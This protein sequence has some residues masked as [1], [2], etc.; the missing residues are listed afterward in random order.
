MGLVQESAGGELGAL[1]HT[2]AQVQDALLRFHLPQALIDFVRGL[3][4]PKLLIDASRHVHSCHGD[5][6][7]WH[8]RTSDL[9]CL[10]LKRDAK[11]SSEQG[12]RLVSRHWLQCAIL[13]S[14]EPHQDV[15]GRAQLRQGPLLA[16]FLHLLVQEP[17]ELHGVRIGT[18]LL[19][20]ELLADLSDDA[21]RGWLAFIPQ[22]FQGLQLTCL[23]EKASC[24]QGPLGLINVPCKH[25]RV[26]EVSVSIVCELWRQEP[27]EAVAEVLEDASVWEAVVHDSNQLNCATLDD[28]IQHILGPE[29]AWPSL[30][31][32][33]EA[34]DIIHRALLQR[35]QEVGEVAQIRAAHGAQSLTCE[36]SQ[37][38]GISHVLD[39]L[40]AA[41]CKQRLD[42][43]NKRVVV[44]VNPAARGI[45]HGPSVVA[46]LEAVMQPKAAP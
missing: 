6:H 20:G 45:G 28:L 33:V 35:G 46:D 22:V 12:I 18:E 24:S 16:V 38:A 5:E 40:F 10:R 13:P 17:A 19:H 32:G 31:V 25:H 4:L 21:L 30:L 29:E 36:R 23:Q 42:L 27:L 44:L 9:Q 34:A 14:I 11:G 37:S 41:I 2:S 3:S 7:L 15:D 26:H 43:W 1:Q 39:Q 8:C